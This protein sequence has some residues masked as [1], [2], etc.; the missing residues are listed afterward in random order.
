MI[1]NIERVMKRGKLF[2]VSACSGAGKTTLVTKVIG[3]ITPEY[4]I[5]RVITY[6]S[7]TPRLGEINGIDYHF[8]SQEEFEQ[9]IGESFFLEWSREYNDYYGSPRSLIDT[10]ATG[11]HAIIITDVKGAGDLYKQIQDATLIWIDVPNKEVLK[12]RLVQ[13]NSENNEQITNRIA[14]S[15]KEQEKYLNSVFHYTI[16]N[17]DLD[18][19]L[20]KLESVIIAEL[21]KYNNKSL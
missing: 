7:K 10:L 13:R 17:E 3:K 12:N 9:K 21:E 19:S 8:V 16:L 2:I 5:S 1:C 6:T 15:I 11:S 4:S 18:N 20:L 14:I